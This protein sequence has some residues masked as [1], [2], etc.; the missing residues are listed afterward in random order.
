[1]GR[2]QKM[3]WQINHFR[4]SL[5]GVFF[6]A[7]NRITEIFEMNPYLMH[8]AC[9]RDGFN[10]RKTTISCQNLESSPSVSGFVN[11]S[12]KPFIYAIN[13]N[14][15]NPQTANRHCYLAFILDDIPIHQSNVFFLHFSVLELLFEP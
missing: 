14:L 15:L 3:T 5:P 13:S 7:C 10:Q 2:M 1:M 8:P 4:N 12:Q 11:I 6:I 9:V